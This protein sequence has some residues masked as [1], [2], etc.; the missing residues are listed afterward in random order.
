MDTIETNRL[1]LRK[2][3]ASDVEPLIAFYS[4]ARSAMAGGNVPY[5][6]SVVRAYAMLG[7]WTHRGY[8]L[9]AVTRRGDAAAA[10]IGMAGPYYPPGRPETEIGWV[11]FD[12]AEGRGYAT[13]AAQATIDYARTVLQW[14]EIVH[15]IDDNNLKSIAVAERLGARLD[16]QAVQPK[17]GKPCLVYRQPGVDESLNGGTAT[18]VR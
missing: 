16:R 4:S 6:E 17:P 14:R 9:F 7:H 18:V 11:L 3:N 12:G 2:P 13:E 1:V 5:A 10:A 8:G 15:Y